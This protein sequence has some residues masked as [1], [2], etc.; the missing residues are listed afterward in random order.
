MLGRVLA[1]LAPARERRA[2]QAALV[3]QLRAARRVCEHE[4]REVAHGGRRQ[5]RVLARRGA[6]LPGGVRVVYDERVHTWRAT[7]TVADTVHV[8][9]VCADE[10]VRTRDA[11]VAA[12]VGLAKRL[13]DYEAGVRAGA[14]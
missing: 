2:R 6:S 7:V 4:W 1:L 12:V 5:Q 14:R 13:A 9:T 8:S 3:E 11:Y 10:F